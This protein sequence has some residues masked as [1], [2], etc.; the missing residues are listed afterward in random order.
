MNSDNE[1]A[2][3]TKSNPRGLEI[4][5]PAEEEAVSLPFLDDSI[6]WKAIYLFSG[7][8]LLAAW[9]LIYD[10]LLAFSDSL[11]IMSCRL[12]KA[13]ISGPLWSSSSLKSPKCFCSLPS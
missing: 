12:A 3:V 10:N 8:V 5:A 6:R 4:A 13:H 11:R 2:Q 1:L 7:T 9:W